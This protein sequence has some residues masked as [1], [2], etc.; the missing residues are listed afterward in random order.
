MPVGIM[1]IL[2]N[3]DT[4][5]TYHNRESGYKTFVKRKTNKYQAENLIPSSPA[6]DD[7][8]PWYDPERDD[9]H[10]DIKVGAREIRLSEHNANFLFSNAKG[11]KVS[12]GKLGNGVKYVV[13]F[14]DTWRPNKKKG[15]AVTIYIYDSHLQP[16]GDSIDEKALDNVKANVAMIP[17]A[18]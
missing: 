12:L 6:K 15:L 18:L 11:A 7:T 17:L 1:Q 4:D 9:K 13:R 14:D 16:T 8:L 2:N 3:T 10:I 5:I